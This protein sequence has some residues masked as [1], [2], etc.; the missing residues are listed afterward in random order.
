MRVF[1]PSCGFLH[2]LHLRERGN[3]IGSCYWKRECALF[4]PHRF[5]WPRLAFG[6]AWPKV[7][8]ANARWTGMLSDN[9]RIRRK[10]RSVPLRVTMARRSRRASR[11][12]L[13]PLSR[14]FA[15]CRDR[16]TY[17]ATTTQEEDLPSMRDSPAQLR[18]PLTASPTDERR[19]VPPRNA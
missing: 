15:N 8:M 2:R 16:P 7:Q 17:P 13:A 12:R 3:A 5:T 10:A 14:T 11:H 1:I 19:Q 4:V 6:D 9:D 18:N